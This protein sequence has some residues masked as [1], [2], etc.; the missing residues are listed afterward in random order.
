MVSNI[1][2]TARMEA[3]KS[4]LEVEPV[5]LNDLIGLVSASAG[6]LARQRNIDFVARVASDVPI[7]DADWEK[8]RRII[9][10]LV[11]NAVKYTD[12]GGLV[13]LL[14]RYE[15]PGNVVAISVEDNGRGIPEEVIPLIFE[16]YVQNKEPSYRHYGD[17]GSGLGLAVVKELVEMHGGSV[18]VES[19][20]GVG[21]RFT[22]RIPVG[23]REW[24]GCD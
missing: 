19:E 7:V 21:S 11:S 23:D 10:N 1:L 8:L 6:F 4:I 24:V 14:V 20:R 16:R 12:E 17:S 18:E 22:V 9:E 3:G 5:D 13:R 2:E 15:E